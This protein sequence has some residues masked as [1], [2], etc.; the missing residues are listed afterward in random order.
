MRVRQ[1][2]RQTLGY[3]LRKC[4][5]ITSSI[6]ALNESLLLRKIRYVCRIEILNMVDFFLG[7]ANLSGELSY[8]R[9]L[10]PEYQRVDTF[11]MR[12]DITSEFEVSFDGKG[13]G[14]DD[15]NSLDLKYIEDISE[16]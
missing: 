12:V 14:T 10:V 9:I 8:F 7:L 5:V 4:G 1:A 2:V 15:A 16:F 3:A 11:M 13:Q 6:R